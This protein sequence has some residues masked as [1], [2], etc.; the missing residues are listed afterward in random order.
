MKKVK[1]SDV[2][3]R[4]D[5]KNSSLSFKEKVNL[6]KK[7]D[8][9]CVDVI[10]TAKISNA[11]T[12]ILFLHTIAPLLTK[13][14]ISCPVDLSEESAEQAYSALS[15]AKKIRLKVS[16]PVSSVQME[17]L[18]GKKPDAMLE[19]IERVIKK[20]AS[21]CDDVEFSALD[22]TRSEPE[23]L[24]KAV[25]TAIS[26]GANTVTICDSAGEMMPR[27]YETFIRDLYKNVKELERV[28]LAAECSNNL[29]MGCACLVAGITAGVGEIKTSADGQSQTSLLS[30]ARIFKARGDFLGTYTD[31]NY[32]ELEHTVSRLGF[33]KVQDIKNGEIFETEK[34]ESL[35]LSDKDDINTVSLAVKKLG[36]DLSDEDI[37][38]VYEEFVKVARKKQITER[39]LEVI[40]ASAALQIAPVYKLKNYTINSGNLINSSCVM[41]LLKDKEELQGVTVGDGPIDAAF[42]CIEQI[43]G[44]KFELDDF[45]IQSVTEGKEAVGVTV[46]KLRSNGKLYSGKGISTDIVESSINAYVNALNKICFEE[47]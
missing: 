12:D 5:A 7:L 46:V 44:R 19:L 28:T 21:L 20:C 17:Y 24:Y 2:T 23:F 45:Q 39:E 6:V 22:A 4:E 40:V 3:L 47:A 25:K 36:Y 37:K 16:A 30:V 18:C 35:V 9:L 8:R 34:R 42:Q 38:N 11:K 27:E 10:E 32:T 13:S 33:L 31:L 15:G 41:T 14:I 1:I 29:D 26:S 43:A